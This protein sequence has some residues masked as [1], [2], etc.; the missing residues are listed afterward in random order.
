MWQLAFTGLQ[1]TNQ[2]LSSDLYL[3]SFY[4]SLLFEDIIFST[5]SKWKTPSSSYLIASPLASRPLTQGIDLI[6]A[7][8]SKPKR[9]VNLTDRGIYKWKSLGIYRNRYSMIK[10][11]RRAKDIVWGCIRS[12]STGLRGKVEKSRAWIWIAVFIDVLERT[13]RTSRCW[14]ERKSELQVA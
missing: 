4:S 9:N 7:N 8:T 1:I 10:F 12:C 11:K 6:P 3:D 14:R 2:Y 5:S 13:K